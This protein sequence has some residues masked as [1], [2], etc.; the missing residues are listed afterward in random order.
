[1]RKGETRAGGGIGAMQGTLG[2]E[3]TESVKSKAEYMCLYGSTLQ[4]DGDMHTE[5]NKRAQ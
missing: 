3:R 5:V 4:S 2:E 1:M